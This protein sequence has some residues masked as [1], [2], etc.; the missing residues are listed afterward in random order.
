MFLNQYLSVMPA[1]NIDY[2]IMPIGV[3]WILKMCGVIYKKQ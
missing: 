1:I 2:F 3:Y